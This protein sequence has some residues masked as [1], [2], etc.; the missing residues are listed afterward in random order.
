MNYR[1]HLI[2]GELSIQPNGNCGTIVTCKVP[3]TLSEGADTTEAG[4][5]AS[6]TATL[7]HVE[8]VS[9]AESF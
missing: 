6:S 3:C 5:C 7:D 4:G 1:A 8:E 2:G 9:L